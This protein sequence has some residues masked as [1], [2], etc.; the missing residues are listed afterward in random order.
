MPGIERLHFYTPHYYVDLDEVAAARGLPAG[1]FTKRIG[2]LQMAVPPPGEDVVTMAAGAAA[3]AIAGLDPD[4]IDMVILGTES[5]I[6]QSKAAAIYVHGLLG[7]P[8]RCRAY[9]IK[10]ACYGATAGLQHALLYVEAN[11]G[12]RALVIASD[13]ARYG[14]GS[15]GEATQG[16]SAVAMVVSDKA[17]LLELEA[18]N[19]FCTEDVMDFWRP[20]YRS[21]ALV[22]GKA[23]VRV[24]VRTLIDCWQ[25]YAA[26]TGRTS[27]D[28]AKFCY[29]LPFTRMAATAHQQLLKAIGGDRSLV[30][31]HLDCGTHYNSITGNCYTGSLYM[32]IASLLEGSST[33]LAGQRLGL[34]SY[35]S[36]CQAEFFS[37]IVAT[38]YR[39]ALHAE[40]HRAMLDGRTA[41]DAAQYE[42]FYNFSLPTDGSDYVVPE[43][44]TGPY[45][46]I[47]I[48]DHQRQYEA[49]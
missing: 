47:G 11:P 17:D 7:L 5:G 6:D 35:G 42:A 26:N 48:R 38:G 20:N 12:R 30:E 19:G 14:L 28:F 1:T 3:G 37:G 45:R 46:L 9:E 41:L 29:H 23:S 36:G 21:E 24:Y 31:E 16:G 8:A 33:D 25:Q 34:F 13:V 2:Q 4:T 22:D 39:D 15:A 32:G 10:Q 40:Q 27:A 43:Y 18:G 49:V 44:E